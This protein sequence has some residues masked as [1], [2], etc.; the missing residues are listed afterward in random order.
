M[1]GIM[2]YCTLLTITFSLCVQKV[3]KLG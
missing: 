3:K 1:K 2:A